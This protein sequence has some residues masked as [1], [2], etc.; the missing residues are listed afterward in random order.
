M[1]IQL[2]FTSTGSDFPL[3][4]LHGNGESHE[5]FEHQ[6]AYFS[7]QYRVIA[8]DTRGHG[9]SPRGT[10]PFS[11]SQF[12]ED[13]YDFLREQG[14]E[15]AHILGFSDGGNIA[16]EFALAHPEMVAKLILNGAN[17]YPEGVGSQALEAM[18]ADYRAA[19][20]RADISE[21]ARREADLL[22]L[23]V[24]EPHIAPESL[25]RLTMPVLVLVGTHDV[26]LQE[27]T[28]LIQ[29]SI[30]GSQLV[31]VEGDHW[32]AANNP[33]EFNKVVEEFLHG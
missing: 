2:F 13:L 15:R 10:A 21:S 11:I 25:S 28:E 9:R 3:V 16:L 1:D 29:R 23:M 12:A 32:I 19:L 31:M 17:L 22:A 4:L 33:E 30:P 20:S 7:R 27:H 14:I 18:E 26:I 24:L 5:Y 6:I 8:V